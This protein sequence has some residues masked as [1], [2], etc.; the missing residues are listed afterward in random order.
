M[1]SPKDKVDGD[2]AARHDLAAALQTALAA[3]VRASENEHAPTRRPTKSISFAP[4]LVNAILANRKTQT[5][6]L[7]RPQ[8]R[9]IPSIA[10]CVIAQPGDRLAVREPWAML[11][12]SIVY[13]ADAPFGV[14]RY[15]PAMYMPW[16][17]SRLTIE[18]THL[19]AE[20]LTDLTPADARAEGAPPAHADSIAWLAQL[21]D[22]I[23]TTPG[24]RWEDRPLVWVIGFRVISVKA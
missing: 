16:D 14:Q 4:E 9:G 1:E 7:I 15:R 17:A 21:W 13:A 11:D 2:E 18:V 19:S 24:E 6:R 10:T 23:F 20:R 3:A 12:G 8:P 5:R 22:V